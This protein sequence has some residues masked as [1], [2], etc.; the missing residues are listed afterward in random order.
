[1]TRYPASL[2]KNVCISLTITIVLVGC[3]DDEYDQESEPTI[4]MGFREEMR[5]F[6]IGISQYGK[7]VNSEFAVIPQNGIELV[8]ADGEP[9]GPV[10]EDY[11]NAI[12]G[13]GQEDLFYG[14]YGDDMATPFADFSYLQNFLDVS[15]ISGNKILVT[16]YCY[17][18][19]KMDQSYQTNESAGYI[20]FAAPI[21]ELNAIPTYPSSPYNENSDDISNLQDARNFLYLINPSEFA[22]KESFIQAVSQTNYDAI[23]IDLFFHDGSEFTSAEI[24][25]LKSKLNGGSRLVICYM[26][27]GEAENYRYY[28][29]SDWSTSPPTWL[30]EENPDWEGNFK[31]HYWDP[32]WQSIIYGNENSYLTKVLNAGFDGVYLDIIDAF[33]YYESQ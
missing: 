10:A 13:H 26:S 14:Y 29:Q 4:D 30:G 22:T 8:T 2:I 1:M 18:E 16:D 19:S 24:E 25:Q 11:L 15:M 21:R 23:I 17:T 33:E 7:S 27:I 20:S 32:S 28:W 12:D 6:V 9:D 3:K 5:S 31:V